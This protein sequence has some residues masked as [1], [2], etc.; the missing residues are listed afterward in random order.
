MEKHEEPLKPEW[1][2]SEFPNS[3]YYFCKSCG[4]GIEKLKPV[5]THC[6]K[7]QDWNG[8]PK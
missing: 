2:Y 5:C 3:Y 4:N 1:N 7:T 8:V 6:G